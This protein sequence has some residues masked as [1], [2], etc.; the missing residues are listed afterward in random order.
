MTDIMRAGLLLGPV[1]EVRSS[2]P[3]KQPAS[4]AAKHL[5]SDAKRLELLANEFATVSPQSIPVGAYTHLNYAFAYIDPSSF[6]VAPMSESD[7]GLYSQVTN[8][9]ESNPGLQVWISIGKYA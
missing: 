7:L 4:S 1:M 3:L 8:L 6:A 5:T 9:K 2:T